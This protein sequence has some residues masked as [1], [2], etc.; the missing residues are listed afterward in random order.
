MAPFFL[1]VN[2][3]TGAGRGVHTTFM[4]TPHFTVKNID[5]YYIQ[6][7]AMSESAPA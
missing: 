2:F 6:T 3:T 4:D 7:T 5:L 1:T